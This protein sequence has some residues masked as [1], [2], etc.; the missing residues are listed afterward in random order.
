[1][2]R[3]WFLAR[4]GMG[5]GV[6]GVA[7]GDPAA[8]A[9]KTK[10]D[11]HWR[12]ARHVQDDWLDEIPGRHRIVFDTT[13]ADGMGMA[14]RFADNYFKANQQAYG[15]DDDEL[16]VVI[17]ARH[18][19]TPF[20]FNNAM[21]AK[22]GKQFSEQA[23][24]LDPPDNEPY[25]NRLD[26]LLEHLFTHINLKNVYAASGTGGEKTGRV[27][28][29]IKKG[30]RFAVCEMSTRSVSGEIARATGGDAKTV[31]DEISANLVPNARL[32]PAGIVAVNRAQERGYSYVYV[33]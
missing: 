29:L 11:V 23:E 9:T 14:L 21:W 1:M 10:E 19:S 27:G 7:M 25:L 2:T 24:F 26:L 32:V 13:S 30:V 16:A 8:A 20:A 6:V 33:T 28:D 4:L 5:A 31:F 22:Y 3:R 12:P 18:R 15:L 17:I